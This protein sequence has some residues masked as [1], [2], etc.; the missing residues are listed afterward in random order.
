MSE[1]KD[2]CFQEIMSMTVDE[3]RLVLAAFFYG[4]KHP[5]KTPE[6][7]VSWAKAHKEPSS[8]TGA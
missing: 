4:E 5:E 7:C 6:E 8:N 3:K 2:R 1:I